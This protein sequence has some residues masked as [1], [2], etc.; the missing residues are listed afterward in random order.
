M[1]CNFQFSMIGVKDGLKCGFIILPD[2]I[3]YNTI[4]YNT[5]IYFSETRLQNTI[6]TVIKNTD[7]LFNRLASNLVI[8]NQAHS[9]T[10]LIGQKTTI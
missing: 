10:W 9:L 4:I 1:N 5:I 3:I 6:G 2:L 7:G 8:L